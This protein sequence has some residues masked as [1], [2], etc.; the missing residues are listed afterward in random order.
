[1]RQ[2]VTNGDFIYMPELLRMKGNF[3]VSMPQ[4]SLDEAEMQLA[5]SLEL[6]ANKA[7]VPASC[8]PRPIWQS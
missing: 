6:S 1:M 8:A 3:L 5:Q 2:V 7:R 4:P